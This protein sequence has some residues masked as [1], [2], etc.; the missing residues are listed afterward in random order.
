MDLDARRL[1]SFVTLAEQLHYGRAARE[2]GIA[3][4]SLSAQI[5]RLEEELDV[6]LFAR[7]SRQ[8]Q[9][10]SAG[11]ALLERARR[12]L[13]ETDETVSAVRRA[14]RLAAGTLLLGT[15]TSSASTI[16]ARVLQTHR[17]RRPDVSISV[18]PFDFS[19]PSH[20]VRA[21]TTDLALVRLP[22]DPVGL[23][24]RPLA[25][26]PQLAM[27]PAGHR[28][29]SAGRLRLAQLYDER[30]CDFP[31][32]DHQQRAARL[33]LE[34]R[35]GVAPKLGPLVRTGLDFYLAV[36]Q[37]DGIGVVPR[38]IARHFGSAPAVTF[39]PVVDAPRSTL[40]CIRRVGADD[41]LFED[42]LLSART[43]TGPL[44]R[45]RT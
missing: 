37:G 26:E 13:E 23:E 33:L 20:G 36:S 10:T 28:L 3:Q 42:F 8:V 35:K 17:R 16:L 14:G 44:T 15:G 6:V 30:W 34:R 41:P 22:I 9:L 29:A 43:A 12:I 1:R 7:S 27:L 32:E 2:L 5:R 24:V 18:R 38:S 4:P 31:A 21:G 39:V 40:A 19:D 45:S 11:Q 25:S